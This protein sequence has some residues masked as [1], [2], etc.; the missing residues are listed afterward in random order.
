MKIT[1]TVIIS[2]LIA[3]AYYVWCDFRQPFW[4]QPGYIRSRRL[5]QMAL[6]VLVWLPTGIAV[7]NFAG[8]SIQGRQ[9]I[10]SLLIFAIAVA[11]GI[12]LL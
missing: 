5:Y 7:L 8:L 9:T 2:Y 11:V 4:N 10:R 6:V 1:A 12:M 3:G